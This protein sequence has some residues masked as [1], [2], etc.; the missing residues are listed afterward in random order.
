MWNKVCILKYCISA[1]HL[2]ILLSSPAKSEWVAR[3][4]HTDCTKQNTT[5]RMASGKKQF[6]VMHLWTNS[7]ITNNFVGN[8][9]QLVEGWQF[10]C[11]EILIESETWFSLDTGWQHE[12]IL[13]PVLCLLWSLKW[14]IS[15]VWVQWHP[16]QD[17]LV[18]HL[19]DDYSSPTQPVLLKEPLSMTVLQLWWDMVHTS[20]TLV[21]L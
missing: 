1:S 11:F 10:I 4:Q 7:Y 8:W 6:E 18:S 21:T 19:K 17:T 3:T 15:L 14:Q 2:L 5:Q 9:L 13:W 12:M 16:L 20:L